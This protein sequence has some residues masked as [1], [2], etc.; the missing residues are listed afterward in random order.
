MNAQ[1]IAR[2]GAEHRSG[3]R[4]HR[5]FLWA[6]TSLAA[7]VSQPQPAAVEAAEPM[8]QAVAQ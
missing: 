7:T 2:A 3:R 4:D 6:A 5:L 8:G 1:A